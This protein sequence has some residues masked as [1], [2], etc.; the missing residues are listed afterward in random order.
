M[1][2]LA[3]HSN[4]FW[5]N[6]LGLGFH[7]DNSKSSYD[8]F[9]IDRSIS[10]ALFK[11][12]IWFEAGQPADKLYLPYR[13]QKELEFSARDIERCGCGVR[14]PLRQIQERLPLIIDDVLRNYSSYREALLH[15]DMNLPLDLQTAFGKT[16]LMVK[17]E[18]LAPSWS[19]L[20]I[21]VE[22]NGGKIG[23]RLDIKDQSLL[24]SPEKKTEEV[25]NKWQ[26]KTICDHIDS[27]WGDFIFDVWYPFTDQ[28]LGI[29]KS[30][31]LREYEFQ[32]AQK[33]LGIYV[34]RLIHYFEDVPAGE[35]ERF[36]LILQRCIELANK[37]LSRIRFKSQC[38][39]E[40]LAD[41]NGLM[42]D[43]G[44][45]WF[46]EQYRPVSFQ[47]WDMGERSAIVRRML[48]YNDHLSRM[49]WSDLYLKVEIKS[50]VVVISLNKDELGF[51][52]WHEHDF[53]EYSK[54]KAQKEGQ[55]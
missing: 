17:N 41:D 10:D 18:M 6:F 7:W 20:L 42:V 11:C 33:Y 36:L 27:M 3:H 54:R 15:Q 25:M 48:Y 39:L 2:S 31:E 35:Q 47:K 21:V 24:D 37:H 1:P 8:H 16:L 4:E 9:C 46:M 45:K 55:V 44:L 38:I 14:D 32:A 43:K 28:F 19:D 53:N 34:A 49:P 51:V 40:E 26:P 52:H 50:G 22:T 23:M 30:F 5:D 13:A 12:L 29:A